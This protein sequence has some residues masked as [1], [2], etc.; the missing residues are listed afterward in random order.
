MKVVLDINVLI[1]AA[2]WDGDS[3]KIFNLIESNDIKLIMSLEILNEYS[4]VLNSDEI[5]QKIKNKNLE[6]RRTIEKIVSISTMVQP[7][8][9]VNV[10]I[11]DSDDNKI[12]ECAVAGNVDYIITNDKHLLKLK[13]YLDIK[14]VTPLE[15]LKGGHGKWSCGLNMSFT[16][17]ICG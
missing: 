10:V 6:I 8:E 17:V 4:E 14:I 3:S 15:F 11:D 2:F 12:I 16:Y 7:L 9:K 5:Q 1:S 13:E